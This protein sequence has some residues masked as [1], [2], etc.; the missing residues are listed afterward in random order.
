MFWLL[1]AW[2]KCNF[3]LKYFHPKLASDA[4]QIVEEGQAEL[5]VFKQHLKFTILCL[6]NFNLQRD[7]YERMWPTSACIAEAVCFQRPSLDWPMKLH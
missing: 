6:F 5:T 7:K 2:E 3:L 1:V 4:T